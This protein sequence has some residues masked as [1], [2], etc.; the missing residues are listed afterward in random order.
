MADVFQ[1]ALRTIM[2]FIDNI[3]YGLIP[4]IYK[5]FIYLSELNLFGTSADNPLQKIVNRIYVLLGIFMLF[6][7][8]FS[9][10]QY[11]VDPNAF[12]DSSKGMGKLVT[13]LLVTLVLL[14]SVPSI[15]G[16]AMNLQKLIVQSN[17]I[18]QLILGSN[19]TG[20]VETDS[21]GNV[22]NIDSGNVEE[23]ARDLQFMLFGAFY[24]LNL[25]EGNAVV[26]TESSPGIFY[27]CRETSGVMGSIDTIVDNDGKCLT[28]LKTN[29][30]G[31]EEAEAYGITLYSF[32][33]YKESQNSPTIDERQFEN[34]D[35]LLWWKEDGDYVIT[36]FPVISTAVGVYVVFLLISFSV[37]IAV[38]AIKLCFLQMV[39]PIAIVSYVDPKESMSNG[40]L[41]NWIKECASTY[42]SL[43]LRLATVFLVML[44][45]SALCE[46]VL[47]PEGDISAQINDIEYNIWIYVFLIIGAFMFAKKVPGM[48][49]SIFGIKLSGELN[50]NPF[51]NTGFATL[52]GGAVGLGVG[53][54]ASGFA[55]AKTSL[56]SGESG[57]TALRRGIGGTVS[58]GLRGGI[59]GV[60]SGGKGAVSKAFNVSGDVARNTAMKANTKWRY[61]MGSYVRNAVGAQ[62]LKE[63]LDQRASVFESMEKS[64][65]NMESIARDQLG[66]KSTKW[67]IIQANRNQLNQQYNERADFRTGEM[68]TYIDDEGIIKQREKVLKYGTEEYQNYYAN[69]LN[70]FY[71]KE[72]ELVSEYITKNGNT[73]EG[74]LNKENVDLIIE[75]ENLARNIKENGI[76]GLEDLQRKLKINPNDSKE[77][78]AEKTAKQKSIETFVEDPRTGDIDYKTFKDIKEAGHNEAARIKNSNRYEDASNAEKAKLSDLHQSFLNKK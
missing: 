60:A 77:V 68:E 2:F 63:T 8:S 24:H 32:Y 26:G 42:F 18:G 52:A 67:K 5:L 23:L 51:K 72:E 64:A 37:D 78:V 22:T 59:S 15:F 40:K 6:K 75:K 19:A 43:F 34:F 14:V 66:K 57:F 30:E 70:D 20:S 53:A 25:S 48:I 29:I 47:V 44:L 27:D 12:R 3:V 7:V 11:I 74:A 50:L 76:D 33:K 73:G 1:N 49:E 54:A 39:A 41:H 4:Q 61:R 58:G 9:L 62:S 10:L 13:N 45:V 69:Q 36:Y 31:Y 38:R 65:G 46:S 71:N 56:D 28:A 16:V 17:A 35:K 55:A 21:E